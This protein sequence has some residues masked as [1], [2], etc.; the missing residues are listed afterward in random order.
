M[1]LE[2]PARRL[3]PTR[4]LCAVAVLSSL[5]IAEEFEGKVTRILDGDTMEVLVQRQTKRIRLFG[6]DAPERDQA[7]GSRA[8]EAA[9]GLAF[10]RTVKVVSHGVDQYGRILGEIVLPDGSL[11]NERLVEQGWAWHYTATPTVRDW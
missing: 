3:I 5:A 4:I 9:G 6:I 7:F 11:L 8:R 2:S 1:R 10:G